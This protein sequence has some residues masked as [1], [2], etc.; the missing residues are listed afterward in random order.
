MRWPLLLALFFLLPNSAGAASF[1][2]SPSSGTHTLGSTITVTIVA[3]TATQ[4]LNA[5]SGTLSIPTDAFDI[6]SVT[7]S[8]SIVNFWVQEPTRTGASVA[9]EGVVLN[10][11]Y[12]GSNG[13]VATVTLR[14]KKVGTFSLSYTSASILANDG[15][16]TNI[17]SGT[18]GAT[19]TVS[20]SAPPAAQ[21]TEPEEPDVKTDNDTALDTSGPTIQTFTEVARAIPSDPTVNIRVR[22]TD[23]SGISE[24]AFALDGG[25][26]IPWE[27]NAEGIFTAK[28]GPGAHTVWLRVTDT[29]QNET[30]RHVLVFVAPLTTPLVGNIP[31]TMTLGADVRVQGTVVDGITS[32][33]LLA[34]PEYIRSPF[35]FFKK[36]SIDTAPTRI[37]TQVDEEG[38]WAV[39]LKGLPLAG[40]YRVTITGQDARGGSSLASD[41]VY[42]TVEP[43][44]VDALL[45]FI[46]SVPVILLIVGALAA[47]AL[48]RTRTVVSKSHVDVDKVAEVEK[49]LHHAFDVM[50]RNINKEQ[51]RLRKQDTTETQTE[52]EL[53]EVLEE[54]IETAKMR[55]EK[56]L[57]EL[58]KSA[59]RASTDTP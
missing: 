23:A 35:F 30:K 36:E 56:Q 14:T 10:P 49:T 34:T 2:V 15:K 18:R 50:Q 21:K 5:L 9:F 13:K 32:V 22:A 53:L 41:P 38:M 8:G 40:T 4:A 59:K 39:S 55:A 47:Y 28:L 19:F 6:V 20:E 58:E 12:I 52:E 44:F 51:A 37:T 43:T 33:T 3:E 17:L 42:I 7:S 24:Y 54:N 27:P 57:A 25:S 45:T 48:R 31:A 1:F 26:F 29:L 46:F 16:G 11:G